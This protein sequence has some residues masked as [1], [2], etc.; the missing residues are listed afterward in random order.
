MHVEIENE[1]VHRVRI[2]RRGCPITSIEN[3]STAVVRGV[4]EKVAMTRVS[5]LQLGVEGCHFVLRVA[6]ITFGREK[7]KDYSNC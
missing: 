5:S 4:V 7:L 1:R 3:Q 6:T 2:S